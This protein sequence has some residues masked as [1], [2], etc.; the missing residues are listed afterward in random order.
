MII[1]TT[2][3]GSLVAGDWCVVEVSGE[4]SPER[5]LR[6]LARVRYR[7]RLT[8]SSTAVT[9]MMVKRGDDKLVVFGTT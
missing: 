3:R 4:T 1:S 7:A 6:I 5:I 2:S 9:V 8:S